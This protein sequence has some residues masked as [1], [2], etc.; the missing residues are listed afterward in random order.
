MRRF[1]GLTT[2]GW[3]IY[4]NLGPYCEIRTGKFSRYT[5]RYNISSRIHRGYVGALTW[6]ISREGNAPLSNDFFTLR[7][8]NTRPDGRSNKSPLADSP[9]YS[10]NLSAARIRINLRTTANNELRSSADYSAAIG[11]KKKKEF[12]PL[13]CV[14]CTTVSLNPLKRRKKERERSHWILQVLSVQYFTSG[15]M[16]FTQK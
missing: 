9:S 1:R 3:K 10:F 12:W 13:I 15:I 6:A 14:K 4:C 11:D 7:R 16:N 2:G 5:F 8:K